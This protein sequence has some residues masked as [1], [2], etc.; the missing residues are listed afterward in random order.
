M[1]A[2]ASTSSS[3]SGGPSWIWKWNTC[4][5]F[6]L[7]THRA[8]QVPA[9]AG[10]YRRLDAS[11]LIADSPPLVGLDFGFDLVNRSPQTLKLGPFIERFDESLELLLKLRQRF[12]VSFRDPRL[13][14]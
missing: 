2:I 8:N 5:H 10:R 12:V 6:I 3:L 11:T 4:L 13:G 1:R 14:R 7:L 9:P